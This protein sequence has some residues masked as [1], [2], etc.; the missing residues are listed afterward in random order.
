MFVLKPQPAGQPVQ[1]DGSDKSAELQ[2]LTQ[3]GVKLLQAQDF[4]E[5]GNP[6]GAS[7]TVKPGL[8]HG[9][10]APGT[11]GRSGNV[12]GQGNLQKTA[13]TSAP[14]SNPFPAPS[15]SVRTSPSSIKK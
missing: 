9:L 5:F 4:G 15:S 14:M 7:A 2:D 6:D 11:S 12:S 1:L 10:A 13:R 8:P 3:D